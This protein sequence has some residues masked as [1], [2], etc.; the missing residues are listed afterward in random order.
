MGAYRTVLKKVKC[1]DHYVLLMKTVFC[2]T[3]MIKD[4]S[5]K[6]YGPDLEEPLHCQSEI[7]GAY[8]FSLS[9]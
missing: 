9:F 8:S 5:L 3:N 4:N 2:D 7:K 1:T 6:L